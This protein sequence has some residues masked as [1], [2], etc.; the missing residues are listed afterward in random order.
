[1]IRS[2][3]SCSSPSVGGNGRPETS[4]ETPAAVVVRGEPGLGKSRLID[5]ALAMVPGPPV[6]RIDARPEDQAADFRAAATLLRG[7]DQAL[8]SSPVARLARLRSEMTRLGL[9]AHHLPAL[10]PLLDIDPEIGF[11]RIPI[12]QSKLRDEIITSLAEWLRASAEESGLVVVIDDLQWIDGSTLD[13]LTHIVRNPIP[14]VGVVIG[15]RPDAPTLPA[16][17]EVID[18]APFDTQETKELANADRVGCRPSADRR[19]VGAGRRQSPV[20]RRVVALLGRTGADRR[21]GRRSAPPALRSASG[22]VRAV[23]R[24]ALCTGNRCGHGRRGRDDFGGRSPPTWSP[25][26]PA[27]PSRTS[28]GACRRC[29]RSGSSNLTARDSASATR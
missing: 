6:I 8:A 5:E 7:G 15:A 10:A 27:S 28:I 25:G 19:G 20:R 22:P 13:L 11:D 17:A 21:R 18:L 24:Q 4:A 23:A 9:A 12:D 16:G 3:A 1:M 26:W 29:R 2:G 14:G